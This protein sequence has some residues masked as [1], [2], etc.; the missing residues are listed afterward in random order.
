MT[1]GGQRDTQTEDLLI[2]LLSVLSGERERERERE[3]K[4]ERERERERDGWGEDVMMMSET[5]QD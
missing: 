4:R 5:S 3:R 2:S 1:I